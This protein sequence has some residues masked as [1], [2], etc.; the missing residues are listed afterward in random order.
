M[1]SKEKHVL[2]LEL[3][4]DP[5]WVNIAEKSIEEILI[6]HAYC[7]QKAATSCISLIVNYYDKAE[8]VEMLTPVV[9]EEWSHFERVLEE[10]K[11]RDLA[12]GMPR[13]DEYVA[14]LFKVEKKGGSRDQQ[15]VEKLLI[16]ALIEARSCERFRL[17]WKNLED[18]SLQ[19]FYYELMVSEAG[20][21]K[22]FLQLAKLYMPEDYVM[23]RWRKIL[24]DEAEILK[25]L[26]VRG[27]RMH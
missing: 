25:N 6:D 19:K 9:A 4:T 2:G 18:T 14:K 15:L 24:E 20:H 5:R 23:D 21:Y 7:E 10:L 17:L 22:N 26:E 11:K 13:K 27:D 12:L 3:P 16:N 1:I 8:L